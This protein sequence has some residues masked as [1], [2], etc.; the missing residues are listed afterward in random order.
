MEGVPTT[1]PTRTAL[2]LARWSPRHLGLAA[3][4][5]FANAGLVSPEEIRARLDG[6]AG[7]RFAAR[8][9]DLVELCEPATESAGESWLR[10]R[11]VDA[12]LPRP[13]VQVSLC[14]GGTE[15]YRLD[16]GYEEW[17]VAA[18]Y[19]GEEFHGRTMEQMRADEAR[20]REIS[21]IFGWTAIGFTSANVLAG[22][23]AAERVVADLIGWTRPLRPRRW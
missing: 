4:D 5:A 12:G 10:L 9:R 19:D 13:S 1:T 11:L 20:R 23:P 17:R 14:S 16:T 7:Q 15:R 6:L 2:D 3:L 8:A 21:T 18:E 22:R